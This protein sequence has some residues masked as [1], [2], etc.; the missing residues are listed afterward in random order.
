MF[1]NK[2][3]SFTKQTEVSLDANSVFHFDL[4]AVLYSITDFNFYAGLHNFVQIKSVK[5]DIKPTIPAPN[6]PHVYGICF[7][8]SEIKTVKELSE[9]KLKY[10]RKANEDI[11]FV[12]D[13]YS[14]KADVKSG[15]IID[16]DLY[17]GTYYNPFKCVVHLEFI[18]ILT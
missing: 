11:C 18:V 2:T 4:D 8:E 15:G 7:S 16:K 10:C 17:I 1:R 14:K 3:I 6:N 5:V 12:F 13:T 9:C